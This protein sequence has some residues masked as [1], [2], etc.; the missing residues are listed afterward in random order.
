MENDICIPSCAVQAM[1][2]EVTVI[3]TSDRKR[4]EAME[5]LGAHH[6]VIS[7]D[8]K[9][10]AV[11]QIPNFARFIIKYVIFMVLWIN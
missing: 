7:K 10:M 2:C 11:R 4:K 5:V 3:S 9:Q 1:G 8:D 6:F